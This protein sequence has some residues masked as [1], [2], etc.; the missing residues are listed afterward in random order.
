[1]VGS[2]TLPAA[3]VKKLAGQQTVLWRRIAIGLLLT[4]AML[5]VRA[6][7]PDSAVGIRGSGWVV[8]PPDCSSTSTNAA[9]KDQVLLLS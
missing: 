5:S 7:L 9:R 1:M 4:F 8:R 2:V 3:Q 6:L